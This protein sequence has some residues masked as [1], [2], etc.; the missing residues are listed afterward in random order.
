M[1]TPS[2][3]REVNEKAKIDM[4]NI[5]RVFQKKSNNHP[6]CEMD[7]RYVIEDWEDGVQMTLDE[8]KNPTMYWTGDQ[9]REL[10]DSIF[11]GTNFKPLL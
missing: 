11:V 10:R 6:P 1:P 4:Y 5:T 9:A 8:N 7:I 2:A 3:W